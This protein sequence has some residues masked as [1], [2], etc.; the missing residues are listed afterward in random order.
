ML[1]H[2]RTIDRV[3]L[4]KYIG[5]AD[6]ATME[7]ADYAISVSFGLVGMLFPQEGQVSQTEKEIRA[8]LIETRLRRGT[9]RGVAYE[10]QETGM[11]LLLD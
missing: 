1:E 8:P 9:E 10:Q 7:D 11:G 2:V 5:R 6:R 4:R 3:R